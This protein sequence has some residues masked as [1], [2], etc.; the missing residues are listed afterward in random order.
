MDTFGQFKFQ[1]A[2]HDFCYSESHITCYI[3][4]IFQI[5]DGMNP[6]GGEPRGPRP[7]GFGGPRFGGPP[8]GPRGNFIGGG[9]GGPQQPLLPGQKIWEIQVPRNKC[10]LVIG[11]GD[12]SYSLL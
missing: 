9:A 6:G 2:Q 3:L 10:G 12:I 5:A 7:Q 8:G 11:R 4:L 1:K